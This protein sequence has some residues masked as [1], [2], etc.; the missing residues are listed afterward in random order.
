MDVLYE[1]EA[2]RQPLQ[3]KLSSRNKARKESCPIAMNKAVQLQK[4]DKRNHL[5]TCC[6]T[7]RCILENPFRQAGESVRVFIS[8]GR[9]GEVIEHAYEQ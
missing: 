4:R 3:E 1:L 8:V 5:S 7:H 9:R 6:I 2:K